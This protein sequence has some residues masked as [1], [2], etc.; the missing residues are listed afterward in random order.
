MNRIYSYVVARD[1]G[2]APNVNAG[3]CT[4]AI[5][6]PRIR[7]GAELGDW[8]FGLW[9]APHRLRVTYAMQVTEKMTFA[10]YWRDARFA[11][12]KAGSAV[13]PDNIYKPVTGGHYEQI[14]NPAHDDSN[15]EH[16][17]SVD[18]VLVGGPFWYFGA[19]PV[20][21]PQCYRQLDLP[22]PRRNHR[23]TYWASEE[24]E[25]I[26]AWLARQGD[27]VV[28]SP[29]DKVVPAGLWTASLR[30]QC[31]QTN[32]RRVRRRAC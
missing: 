29:R 27:G 17:L 31:G 22:N 16:D 7:R 4:L 32:R 20:E 3:I 5:C 8:I 2:A 19:E 23:V 9:P 26:L 1:T 15:I 21:L 25:R 24:L 6:K 13:M 11:M 28:G 30:G 18:A 10:E 14:P 12:K